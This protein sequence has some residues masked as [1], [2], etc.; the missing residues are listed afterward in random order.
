MMKRLFS[1]GSI[2]V[3]AFVGLYFAATISFL[4]GLKALDDIGAFDI[5]DE[6]LV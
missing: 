6:D 5:D 1:W 4:G 2:L 3:A